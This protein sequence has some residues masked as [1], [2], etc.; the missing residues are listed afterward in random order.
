MS[1]QVANYRRHSADVTATRL[2]NHAQE[3]YFFMTD[4]E[5]DLLSQVKHV[6]EEIA[7]GKRK[8]W[9]Q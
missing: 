5:R 4:R 6:L 2:G 7:E 9:A 8:A 3:Y 1:V